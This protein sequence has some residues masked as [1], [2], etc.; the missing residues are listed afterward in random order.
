MV[1]V[2]SCCTELQFGVGFL[3]YGGVDTCGYHQDAHPDYEDRQRCARILGRDGRLVQGRQDRG[4]HR[5]V[6]GYG[7]FPNINP[8]WPFSCAVPITFFIIVVPTGFTPY[9]LRLGPH[10]VL[11]FIALEQ[12]NAAY[13]RFAV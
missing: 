11:T 12:M 3:G 1:R 6:E 9:F 5:P 13:N 2:V 7:S 4:R 10:T 8:I